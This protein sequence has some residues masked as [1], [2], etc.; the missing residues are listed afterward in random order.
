MRSL[1]LIFLFI[2][3]TVLPPVPGQSQTSLPNDTS[4]SKNLNIFSSVYRKVISDAAE[5]ID[6]YLFMVTGMNHMLQ[7]VDPY[8]VFL[9]EEEVNELRM[10]L[11]GKFGGIGI[12][13]GYSRDGIFIKETFA[14]GPA[15]RAG[16]RAADLILNVNGTSTIGI[17]FDNIFS[18]LR[19]NPGT[20]VTI[21]VKH[22]NEQTAT[23][24]IKREQ[25][26]ISP[27]RYYGMLTD[28]IA[29][30]QL[31]RVTDSCSYE[32][33][34]AL[35]ELNDK[36]HFKSLVFDVRG[37]E[38]GYMREAIRIANLFLPKKTL[39]V[40]E[41]GRTSDTSFYANAEAVFPTTPLVL[42]TDGNTVSSGEI[43]TGA[44]QDND[45]A[46]LIGQKT[47]GKGLIQRLFDMPNS[48]QLKLTTAR[49]HTPSGRCIQELRYNN[50]NGAQYAD[51]LKKEFK[52]RNG[53][54]LYS[55]GGIS[56]DIKMYRKEIPA[57]V[58][59]LDED[60]LLFDFATQY[61]KT[62]PSIA[63]SKSFHLSDADYEAF[64][65]FVKSRKYVYKTE[66]EKKFE[67]F[68]QTA[69]EEGYWNEIQN[70][71]GQMQQ[72]LDLLRT[73]NLIINKLAVKKAL[74]QEIISRYYRQK[75]RYE[76]ILQ[77]DMEVQKAIEILKDPGTYNKILQT[78]N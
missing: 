46:V 13:L 29:Y 77:S 2:L 45:R 49:Y 33:A 10:G 75:G 42:L 53:R 59:R 9:T 27:I 71:Y 18:L 66:T 12:G 17:P 35:K 28:Q 25:I 1:N 52:S 24:H 69:I 76:A 41:R 78:S 38:G 65:A 15:E 60:L 68:K 48:T 7:T 62:H 19:G 72:K 36:Y 23:Y 26:Y 6:P 3:I 34:K 58:M 56:P 32:V 57:I 44:L 37:N 63:S 74:E 73:N 20:Q 16:L 5:T 61:E 21:T 11:S 39:L 22:V 4:L 47:F 14:G 8:T 70:D 40:Q 67:N 31:S 55:N 30:I 50:G 51:S 64:V 43:L 54:S